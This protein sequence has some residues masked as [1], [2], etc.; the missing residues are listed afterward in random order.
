MREQRAG[1][2]EKRG[3][4]HC[5]RATLVPRARLRWPSGSAVAA[6]AGGGN[7]QPWRWAGCSMGSKHREG[8]S[9]CPLRGRGTVE[10]R[11]R[12]GEGYCDAFRRE[13]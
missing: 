1:C 10:G 5:I 8:A 11:G 7:G 12:R 3:E 13:G 4:K 2:A 9:S 6:V